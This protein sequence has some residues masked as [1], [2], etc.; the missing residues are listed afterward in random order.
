MKGNM[1]TRRGRNQIDLKPTPGKRD[2]SAPDSWGGDSE[3]SR[4][5]V[6]NLPEKKNL[7][8]CRS[9]KRQ[10]KIAT[11]RKRRNRSKGGQR[12]K[13]IRIGGKTRVSLR[14]TD[15]ERVALHLFPTEKKG[16]K[17]STR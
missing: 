1:H 15:I 6:S 2:G 12:G 7:G 9:L 13:N 11:R 8:E 17:F 3:R 14:R 16:G 10:K 4:N 5:R